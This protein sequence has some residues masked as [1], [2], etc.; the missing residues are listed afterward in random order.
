MRER[1][2]MEV[3]DELLAWLGAHEHNN[4]A[5]FD[6]RRAL[7]ARP[8]LM[9]P[10]AG[11]QLDARAPHHHCRPLPRRRRAGACGRARARVRVC[12][13]PCV[14]VFVCVCARA[15]VFVFMRM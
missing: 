1:L 4:V 2:A 15:R 6:V 3:L 12:V 8:A 7:C 5:I 13:C 14:R 10:G 11:D 9:W